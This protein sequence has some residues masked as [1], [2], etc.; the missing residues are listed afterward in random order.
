MCAPPLELKQERL[1]IDTAS[2]PMTVVFSQP[3]VQV[4]QI[5][6]GAADIVAT[7]AAAYSAWG[8]AGGLSGITSILGLSQRKRERDQIDRIFKDIRLD[9]PTCHILGQNGLQGVSLE[10]SEEAFG[11][12]LESNLIGT[13]LCALAYNVE[14]KGAI[15]FLS[16]FFIDTLFG[17]VLSDFPG[18]KETIVAFLYDNHGTILNEGVVHN[19]EA[20]FD[21]ALSKLG[22][23][24]GLKS[25]PKIHIN[26]Y[27]A[28]FEP[29]SC[30]LEGLFTWLLKTNGDSPYYTR[31]AIVGRTA[32]CLQCIGY[33]LGEVIIW[34]GTGKRPNPPRGIVL[35]MGGSSDTDE[36][37]TPWSMLHT[38]EPVSHYHWK[39]A[40]VMFYSAFNV[41]SSCSYHEVFQ[42]DFDGIYA[43]ITASL[44]GFRWSYVNKETDPAKMEVQ[45]YPD[46]NYEPMEFSSQE[47]GSLASVYF[48]GSF[49]RLAPYYERIAN[50]DYISAVRWKDWNRGEAYPN[51]SKEVQRFLAVTASICLSVIAKLAGSGFE[52][53]RH[54]TL[55]A[56]FNR[57]HFKG[58]CHEV[59]EF[60]NGGCGMSRVVRAI[61]AVHCA[62]D[63]T[64]LTP[65]EPD[66]HPL[67]APGKPDHSP[68]KLDSLIGWRSGRYAVLPN[69]V[70]QLSSPLDPCVLG[71]SCTDR[72]IANLP[73]QKDGSIRSLPTPYGSKVW[74]SEAFAPWQDAT[75]SRDVE[76]A[77]SGI[78]GDNPIVLGAP[79]V[80]PPTKPLY[81]AVERPPIPTDEPVLSLS[82][83]VDGKSIG[84]V[85]IQH[86]L[87]T[88]A[89]SWYDDNGN[90]IELCG[91]GM[92][93]PSE[94]S[95]ATRVYNMPSSRYCWRVDMVPI[96]ASWKK[97]SHSIYVQLQ[98]DTPWVIFLAGQSLNNRVA[99]RCADCALQSGVD[100]RPD[101]QAVTILGYR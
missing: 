71:L 87:I 40:G 58:L 57:R 37:M 5:Q 2:M 79:I 8:W 66:W 28:N 70:F 3:A 10:Y 93:H 53:L 26:D 62:F 80:K 97:E 65:A 39:T 44:P 69:L 46:W 63:L 76:K 9:R 61:A 30:F 25:T 18:S 96:P 7:I 84:N 86:V 36:L 82:G 72:F 98:D 73:V 55:S 90:P 24:H 101:S 54:S 42:E 68:Y 21:S 52:D 13:T 88:L 81:L 59:D 41:D 22:S 43:E 94:T 56:I 19:L 95:Y 83:R 20:K 31:S 17:K 64:P 77:D 32:V 16:D 50:Y 29:E 14:V 89:R 48:P 49:S 23:L 74:S 4:Q 78:G 45:A 38:V 6:V 11:G 91:P 85:G 1:E 27:M 60:L 34:D 33:K 67:S 75:D 12:T 92:Q 15:R 100:R 35:V 51:V 47:A 99:F